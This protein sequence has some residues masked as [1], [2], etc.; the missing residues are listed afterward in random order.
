MEID[1]N[2]IQ[3]VCNRLCQFAENKGIETID[4]PFDYYWNIP[5]KQRYDIYDKPS[6]F[7]LGQLTDDWHELQKLLNL[8]REPI[9]YEFAWLG[10][11][12]TAIG[13]KLIL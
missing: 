4:I 12:L 9:G 1:L 10:S 3:T 13:E 5:K 8:Q 11:I 7:D 6:E 2:E